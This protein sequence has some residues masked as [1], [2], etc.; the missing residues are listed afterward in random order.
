M[1][2]ADVLR[3]RLKIRAQI[4]NSVGLREKVDTKEVMHE[5]QRLG[6]NLQEEIALAESEL[7][8][9]KCGKRPAFNGDLGLCK[10]CEEELAKEDYWL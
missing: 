5:M 1:S 10:Q 9:N 3:E 7:N 6:M 4:L 2:N 8:C